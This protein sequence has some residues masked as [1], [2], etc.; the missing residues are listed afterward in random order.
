[1]KIKLARTIKYPWLL[2]ISMAALTATAQTLPTIVTQPQNQTVSYGSNATF[3]VVADGTDLRF[4]WRKVGVELTDYSNVAGSQTASLKLVG[5]GQRDAADYAVVISNGAGAITSSIA[6][7]TVSAIVA[8]ADDFEESGLTNWT[9]FRGK[10]SMVMAQ[11]NHTP[12]G[13]KSVIVTNSMQRMY[14][15]LGVELTGRSRATFWVYENQNNAELNWYGEVR[16]YRGKGEM[17]YAKGGLQQIFAIGHCSGVDFSTNNRGSLVGEVLDP[18]KYQGRIWMGTNSGWF[19]LNAAGA[20]DRAPGWHKFE[21]ERL[22]DGTTIRFK[23]DGVVGRTITGAENYSIDC[24]TIGSTGF[25]SKSGAAWFDDVKVE[26]Y[27]QRFDWE[28]KDSEGK[29]LFDWMKLRETGTNATVTDIT[30]R[31]TVSEVTGNAASQTL[32]NWVSDGAGIYAA[33]RRGYVEYVLNAPADEAYRIE[34]EGRER[35]YKRPFVELPLI[36]SIDGEYLGRF[37]LPYSAQANG[38]V[39]CFTPFIKAGPH[40]IRIYWDN[41]ESRCSLY[42]QGVRLQSLIG[43]DSNNNGIKDWVENRLLSQSG[44]E[45]VS[46]SSAVSPFCIEGRGQYLSMMRFLAGTTEP[47]ASLPIHPGTGN[48]WYCDVPLSQSERTQ[49]AV[50]HQNGGLEETME[51][52]WEETNLLEADDIAIRKGDSL[53]LTAVPAGQTDGGVRIRVEGTPDYVTDVANPVAHRFDQAGTFIV[54][55]RFVPTGVTRSIN[56]RVVEASFDGPI[57]TWVNHH[58]YVTFTNFLPAVTLDADPRIK[59]IRVPTATALGTNA[60]QFSVTNESTEART[61]VARLGAKGPVLD[62]TSIRGFRLFNSAETYLNHIE[63]YQ[64]GSQLI[65]AAYILSPILPEVVVELKVLAGGVT[66]DDGTVS[67]TLRAGDFDA[68]GICRVRYIRT[69]GVTTS[70]CHSTKAY[71]N[72]VLI[73]WPTNP[74]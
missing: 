17:V 8:F 9:A 49:I 63:A 65:E 1:M 35:S 37:I 58:R 24:V 47:L 41:A 73:G 50:S 66:F 16:G 69:A 72:G 70:I 2:V 46:S 18:T 53:L 68:L 27:P 3:T 32:G 29:G 26:A 31:N 62:S 39:R 6:S 52:A 38:F 7:L 48:R 5:V 67:R 15:N 14:H 44:I 25:G 19:N 55:G 23:V 42:L 59:A 20:P 40:T 33:D 57:A 4:Q 71:Q 28:S 13:S 21:I 45:V 54:T 60:R 64:D 56:V 11:R 12:S 36:V 34:I 74:K 22:A 61:I 10:E 43:P 30:Q 51:I